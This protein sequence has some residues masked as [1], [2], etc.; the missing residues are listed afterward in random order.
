MTFE[1]CAICL[2]HL[3]RGYNVTFLLDARN[4]FAYQLAAYAIWLYEDQG[5]FCAH[6][7]SLLGIWA[8]PLHSDFA[9]LLIAFLVGWVALR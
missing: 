7:P 6:L 1:K 5:L 3:E 4:Y 2:H 9:L 8:C